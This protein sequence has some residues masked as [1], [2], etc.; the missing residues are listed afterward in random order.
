MFAINKNTKGQK[1]V[2]LIENTQ[3]LYNKEQKLADKRW[4][5]E[6]YYGPRS[7]K[8]CVAPVQS[9]DREA[10]GIDRGFTLRFSY[11]FKA[12]VIVIQ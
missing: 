12:I 6:I 4:K 8:V 1:K 2:E 9:E 7:N 3:N 11:G 5:L 10:G